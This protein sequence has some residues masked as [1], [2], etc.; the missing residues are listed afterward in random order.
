MTTLGLAQPNS[1]QLCFARSCEIRSSTCITCF[2]FSV[3]HRRVF[4]ITMVIALLHNEVLSHD[5][6]CK[7]LR[8]K[9][10]IHILH[11][12]TFQYYFAGRPPR[13]LC[14][15]YAGRRAYR[16]TTKS[17]LPTSV[18]SSST[19]N[20]AVRIYNRPIHGN[21][22]DVT[23]RISRSVTSSAISIDGLPR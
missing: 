10:R 12:F 23:G 17:H 8:K 6:R 14:T 11:D 21:W 22:G 19:I 3:L 13:L 9:D 15:P 20:A 4:S 16:F 7:L 5:L 1:R 18:V 2:Y